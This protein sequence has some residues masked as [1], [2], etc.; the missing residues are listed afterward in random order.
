MICNIYI[1]FIHVINFACPYNFFFL[2]NVE[3]KHDRLS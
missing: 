3:L 1:L 2:L